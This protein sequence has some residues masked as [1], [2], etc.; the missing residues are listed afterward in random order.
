[1]IIVYEDV[2][3]LSYCKY[4][5]KEKRLENGFF[6]VDFGGKKRYILR[7]IFKLDSF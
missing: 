4:L 2:V 7:L 6:V 3:I 1:M 5:K